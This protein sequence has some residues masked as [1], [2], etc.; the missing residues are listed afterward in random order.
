MAA[1]LH[2]DQDVSRLRELRRIMEL[3]ADRGQ[4]LAPAVT[5]PSASN[6]RRQLGR[7]GPK[8]GR[9]LTR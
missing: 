6:R 9:R 2:R 7:K 1:A 4:T 8:Q 5:A 3:G